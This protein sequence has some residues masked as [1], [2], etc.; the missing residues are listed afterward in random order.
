M[1]ASLELPI[2]QRFVYDDEPKSADTVE[3]R[4][5]YDGRLPAQS[6]SNARVSEK[7]EIRKVFHKQL[8]ELCKTHPGLVRFKLVQGSFAHFRR[9]PFLF[10]P[11][12]SR[13]VGGAYATLDILFLRRD[14]PG[15]VLDN[16]DLDNRIKVLFDALKVPKEAGELTDDMRPDE[17][18]NPFYCLLDDD[19]LITSV[20]I[21]T[22][23]LLTPFAGDFKHPLS[24]TMLVIHVKTGVFYWQNHSETFM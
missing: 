5:V 3:F 15:S 7:H 14:H 9:D 11:L 8:A 13:N 2:T 22:D 23:R 17:D 24:D 21:T 19:S 1:P 12:I 16:S 4:L 6:R 18:E 10:A 20:N